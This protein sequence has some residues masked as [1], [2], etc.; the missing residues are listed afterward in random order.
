MYGQ[1]LTELLQSTPVS[2][3]QSLEVIS[4]PNAKYKAQGKGDIINIMLKKYSASNPGDLPLT[5]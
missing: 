1:N 2:Q 3:V 4:N 5:A